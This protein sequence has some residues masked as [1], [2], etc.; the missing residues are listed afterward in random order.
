V[1]IDRITPDQAWRLLA[2]GWTYVD[3]RSEEEFGDG[4]PRGAYNVPLLFVTPGG[5]VP[6][7]DFLAMMRSAF[8]PGTPLILGCATA[9]R[10][11]AAAEEL[12][13][14]GFQQLAVM[15]GGWKG[16][17]GG[18]HGPAVLGWN[19]RGLPAATRPEPGRSYQEIKGA[20]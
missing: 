9:N 10:S 3:V 12:S 1:A 14:A 17:S 16:E 6:N 19:A 7:P 2:Q 4:H 20:P 11:S 5:R 8:A 18:E 13:K 15:R